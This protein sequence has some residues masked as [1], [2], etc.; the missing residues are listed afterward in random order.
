M[1]SFLDLIKGALPRQFTTQLVLIMTALLIASISGY[2][3]FTSLN[4][5]RKEQTVLMGRVGNILDNLAIVGSDRL[6]T[7][8]YSG[9]ELL[10]LLAAKTNT[11]LRVLRVFSGNGQLVSQVMRPPGGEPVAVFDVTTAALPKEKNVQYQWL[12]THGKTMEPWDFEW[13]AAQMVVW[14]PLEKFGYPGF[15]QAEISTAFLKDRIAQIAEDGL[16]AAMI[17]CGLGVFLLMLYLRRPVA[18]IMESTRFA[19][20]LTR[21]LGDQMPDYKGPREIESLIH[22]LNETSLWLYTKEMSVTAAQQRLEALFS[23][24][25]D[26]LIMVNADGMI[27]SVN[28]AACEL[29]GY[30]EHE[31]VGL[32]I[33]NFLPDWNELS[34]EGQGDKVSRETWAKRRDGRVFPSDATLS[35]FTLHYLPYRIVVVR[36]ITARK[37][38]EESLR[39]AKEAAEA[40]NRMKS[41]F[42]ANMSHE[43]RTPMNGVIGM[44]ELT[45]DTDLNDEQREYLE[46]VKSSANHLLSIINEI[47]DFSKIEAGRLDIVPVE[48]PL[49]SFMSETV[50]SLEGKARKKGLAM[51][52]T[53][54]KN[55]PLHLRADSLRLRQ[56]LINL[57][58]NALKFTE[59]GSI[60][61]SVEEDR[62]EGRHC[63]HFSVADTG[64]G[65]AAAKQDF[66][67]DAFTQADGSITRKFGG[68]GLGLTIS[69]KLVQLMGGRVWVE[70]EEGKGTC[71]H[72]TITYE[73]ADEE[74]G[75]M[76]QDD[77]GA[78]SSDELAA[79]I[80]G[81][82]ILL[83]EDN[84]VNRRLAISLLEKLGHRVTTVPD[85][86]Q[87]I[88]A[89]ARDKFDVILMDMMMP[90]M[91]GLTAIKRIRELESGH[92]PTPII[93]LTAHTMNGERER[94]LRQGADG[95]VAKPIN[96]NELR[97]AISQAITR[98][99][100]P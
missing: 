53:V 7:R 9:V 22:A 88:A 38:A 100:E 90:E 65:I 47:L 42:L 72:F 15:L 17:S 98:V 32:L 87:A 16:I 57:L 20:D 61:L 80:T 45:L 93:A 49:A 79:S 81:L 76:A 44:T 55:L 83:A 52:L 6:L 89:Y 91:D 58:S 50:K 84:A 43:I 23:N 75:A 27:E 70:S 29:F 95:Y 74:P 28:D 85:G 14:Y 96:F 66:I 99:Q 59:K 78:E 82:R 68:T 54:A 5:A 31:M 48:F 62:C 41:E 3:L 33:I 36:D 2:T 25:S 10:L 21:H 46:L 92:P 73:P 26:A 69:A 11:E 56:V 40:A 24:I 34:G 13:S 51:T 86:A 94:I 39:H 18:V 71:F 8:D 64:I 77:G 63:L 30:S 12:D 4:Q 97:R 1:H 67:F 60:S 35:L 19:E 37:Q